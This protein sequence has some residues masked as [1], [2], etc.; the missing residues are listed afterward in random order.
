MSNAAIEST[1]FATV[2]DFV[3]ALNLYDGDN[4][5]QEM[6]YGSEIGD[7]SIN[8]ER[9]NEGDGTVVH[10]TSGTVVI[11]HPDHKEWAV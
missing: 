8:E 1:K 6:I 4:I 11:W 7:D 5:W 2:K 10:L 9:C 3:N